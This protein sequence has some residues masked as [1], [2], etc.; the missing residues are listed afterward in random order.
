MCVWKFRQWL[1]GKRQRERERDI[2]SLTLKYNLA[3][4]TN[5]QYKEMVKESALYNNM[6][7]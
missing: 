6:N 3:I 1:S 5:K 2:D 7:I 4:P